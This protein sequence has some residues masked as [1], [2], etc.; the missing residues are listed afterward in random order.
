VVGTTYSSFYHFWIYGFICY[1]FSCG[2]ICLRAFLVYKNKMLTTSKKKIL[3]A[4][5]LLEI[6]LGGF[7]LFLMNRNNFSFQ[8]INSTKYIS[9]IEKNSIIS[10]MKDDLK[11]YFEL[12][13]NKIQ[14]DTTEWLE[15]T[16][17]Y[18]YNSDGL[19][20]RFDYEIT[21]PSNTYRV[22]TLG[23]SFT[24]GQ[25]VNTKDNWTEKLEDELNSNDKLCPGQKYE[26]INLGMP[27]FDI[28]YI[29]KR[30]LEIGTK[31][32]PDL[33]IWFE[34]NTGFDRFNEL[35][36]PLINQCESQISSTSE[37]KNQRYYE[38]WKQAEENLKSEFNEDL[39]R[40]MLSKNLENLIASANGSSKLIYYTLRSEELSKNDVKTL[41]IWKM[42][43]PEIIFASTVPKLESKTDLH[44]DNHPNVQ[45]HKKITSSIFL[46]LKE[47]SLINCSIDN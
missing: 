39:L 6:V 30:Y 37:V 25:F 7:F 21:K 45:G 26:V 19:H 47:Q 32:D 16:I 24:Y 44:P 13:P 11:F 33:I 20:D 23:D 4:I 18:N 43:F 28:E 35:S 10:Q 14:Q 12:E 41:E 46:H 40:T 27:G 15:Q 38:C 8:N 5:V 22:I 2:A 31:Y 34:S 36:M 1:Y 9:K 29:V 3:L 42:M 17:I